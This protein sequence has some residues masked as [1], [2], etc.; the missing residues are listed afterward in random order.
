MFLVD[1]IQRF[2]LL[3]DLLTVGLEAGPQSRNFGFVL[4][5]LAR[6][7]GFAVP[8]LRQLVIQLAELTPAALQFSRQLSDDSLRL[9]LFD[10][11]GILLCGESL[12]HGLGLS[13]LLG[14]FSRPF[15]LGNPLLLCGLGQSGFLRKTSALTQKAV[16]L[17]F[18]ILGGSLCRNKLFNQ[19]SDLSLPGIPLNRQLLN[20]R[21]DGSLLLA[22]KLK[23]YLQAVSLSLQSFGSGMGASELLHELS[24]LSL[25]RAAFGH[26]LLN[27]RL[28]R[29]LFLAPVF[30]VGPEA[31]AFDG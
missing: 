5:Q 14:Q 3:F 18:Q 10:T 21:L 8:G 16:S 25:L 12:D 4:S 13:Q 15:L 24:S 1:S 11:D 28:S 26:Q 23:L 2:L 29:I 7:A 22:Q 20:R 31:L 6:Q 17:G 19:L 9:F 27:R 30:Q